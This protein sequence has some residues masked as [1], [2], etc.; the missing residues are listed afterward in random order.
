MEVILN[1]I[2]RI[3][4]P[5]ACAPA[6]VLL[7]LLVPWLWRRAESARGRTLAVAGPVAGW[8]L[9]F[10]LTML[11]PPAAQWLEPL[12]SPLAM[13]FLLV[14][15]P[16]LIQP[17]SGPWRRRF[18]LVPAAFLLLLG[19][20][21][22]T[23][24][25]TVPAGNGATF[26]WLLV[27]PTWLVAG[28]TSVLVLAQPWLSLARFRFLVRSTAFLVLVYGG[29]ALRQNW[30]DRQEMLGRRKTQTNIMLLAETAPVMRTD[31]QLTHLPSAP[32]RF[33]PDGGYVQ[34]CN[35]ELAQ[36][37]FQ[38]DARKVA[39]GEPGAVSVLGMC[40]GSLL[41][42]VCLSFAG[43][44]WFCGWLCPLSTA[45]NVLDG[46]RRKLG[47]PA[48]RP[49]RGVLRGMLAGGLGLG[50]LAGGAMA[51][52]YPYLDAQGKMLGCKLPLYPF[53]K[54]CP[55]QQLCPVLGGG[56]G[57]YPPLPGTEWAFGFFRYGC[58]AIAALY[59]LCFAT[60]RRLW[61]WF[62]PMGMLSGL[63][64]RGGLVML[65][66]DP[67][68]CNRC[69]VCAEVCPMGLEG[70]RDEMKQTDVGAYGCV[71]CLKCVEKCP[72]D[73]CLGLDHAGLPVTRSRFAGKD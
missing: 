56:P 32:C 71:L 21:L 64:N 17:E 5:F 40:L 52:A 65:R 10:H 9:L 38:I 48:V 57:A 27:R 16:A 25:R 33:A 23:G 51:A 55:N 59:L 39:E 14:V 29:F 30:Q 58:L 66:K 26:G 8:F 61:C 41:V 42:L 1:L 13:A 72:R 3:L 36:R 35:L 12:D 54:I 49:A 18:R 34:G 70:M 50:A 43:G 37:F 45:G 22:W 53:C 60:S 6:A 31:R 47:L 63:F 15:W 19:L 24:W 7:P 2:L 68:R 69:G 46:I 28:V 4:A 62:C 44:R 20:G 73:G 11:W 67:A